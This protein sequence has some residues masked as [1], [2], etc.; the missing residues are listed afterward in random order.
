MQPWEASRGRQT[1]TAAATAAAAAAAA[2]MSVI[3]HSV[4]EEEI[5]RQA[6][7]LISSSM[8]ATGNTLEYV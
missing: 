2:S 4:Q 1:G 8:H 3:E 7:E 5:H 6:A